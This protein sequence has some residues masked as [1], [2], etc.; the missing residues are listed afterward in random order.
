MIIYK[1]TNLVNGK[2]YIG[3]DSKNNPN[4][5]GSGDLI[6]KA[7]NKYGK[8]NFKKEILE[9]CESKE[10][11]NQQ[12]IYWINELS[13]I[14]YG[15]NILEGGQGGDNFKN[16][17]NLDEI[18]EKMSLAKKGKKLSKEHA[19]KINISLRKSNVWL[20][21]VKS[22][23]KIN[24][25]I[26]TKTENNTLKI[27]PEHRK[28]LIENR[29]N[30]TLTEE[31]KKKISDANKN[32]KF[33]EEHKNNLSKAKIGSTF[34]EEHKKKLSEAN[35]GKQLSKE[36]KNKIS[37]YRIGKKHSDETKLKLKGRIVSN[38]T[39]N[40]L[41]N[42]HKGRKQNNPRHK[43]Y[44]IDLYGEENGITMHLKFID[45]KIDKFGNLL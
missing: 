38:E 41:S 42:Y 37:E 44:W 29:E 31:H 13:G 1:T 30:K 22:E 9:Y 23:E 11:L 17:P 35:K 7:I 2:F 28:K 39:K 40:I 5:L 27:T 6:K 21:S 18:K 45:K 33:S 14:T 26:H 43:H 25:M 34:S 15:Y 12:E 10:E 20:N 4:Y 32:K 19:E 3:Q 8:D 24:K 36:T 16:H